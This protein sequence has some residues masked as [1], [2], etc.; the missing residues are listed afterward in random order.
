MAEGGGAADADERRVRQRIDARP[1]LPL[2]IVRQISQYDGVM[3]KAFV[4]SL[5]S[6]DPE[7]KAYL[8]NELE[9]RYERRDLLHG[10]WAYGGRERFLSTLP[11]SVFRLYIQSLETVPLEMQKIFLRQH[12]RKPPVDFFPTPPYYYDGYVPERRAAFLEIRGTNEILEGDDDIDYREVRAEFVRRNQARFAA[13]DARL[14]PTHPVS[15]R[16]QLFYSLTE[17][18]WREYSS[19]LTTVA[20]HNNKLQPLM[21][22]TLQSSL[23]MIPH[24]ANFFYQTI[25]PYKIPRDETAAY[26]ARVAERFMNGEL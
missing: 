1:D 10:A 20:M 3:R 21:V 25:K 17:D 9:Q 22:I 26:F 14:P 12:L 2:D 8:V 16:L 7:R 23:L 24:V 13:D 15:R 18:I 19:T 6:N 4:L 5:P 11:I